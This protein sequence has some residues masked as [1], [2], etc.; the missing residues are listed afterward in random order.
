[1]TLFQL[2]GSVS[3][4]EPNESTPAAVIRTSRPPNSPTARSTIACTCAGS[5]T[6]TAIP[7]ARPP[8]VSISLATPSAASP[9]TSA[10]TTAAPSAP[11]RSETARPMP[12][13][14][15]VTAATL[16]ASLP[17][18]SLISGS[19]PPFFSRTPH[20]ESFRSSIPND[21]PSVAPP[22]TIT[23]SPVMYPASS[24]TRNTTTFAMSSAVP[25]RPSGIRFR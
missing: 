11:N 22:S 12:D 9:I 13:P 21:T 8:P 6:S 15:P 19:V 14:P 20:G 2:S 3:G 4:A 23:S 10:T 16:P 7:T 25:K 1:M 17:F 5:L 18:V 24:D